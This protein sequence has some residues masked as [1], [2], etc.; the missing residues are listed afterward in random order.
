[1]KYRKSDIEK[2]TAA[3]LTATYEHFKLMSNTN[4][5]Y[6]EYCQTVLNILNQRQKIN[7]ED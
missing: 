2:L 6:D 5:S 3:L 7:K 1:M 4:I